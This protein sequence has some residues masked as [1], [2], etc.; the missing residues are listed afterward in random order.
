M[1]DVIL[2]PEYEELKNVVERLRNEL[3]DKLFEKDE[4]QFVICKN[5]DMA[6]MLK[7]G[8]LEY[9]VYE[10]QCE[11]LRLKRKQELIQAKKNRQELISIPEIE[12]VLD[13]EFEEYQ[14]KLNDQIE[15]MNEALH[16]SK[17]KALTDEDSKRFK[18]MYHTVVKKL[19]PDLNPN[20]TA[21]QRDMFEKAVEAYEHGDL[22][23][24]EI[25]HEMINDPQH[26][27]EDNNVM[28]RLAYEKDRLKGL[29]KVIDRDI[30]RIKREYPY[31]VKHLVDDERLME[32]ERNS[33]EEL[34]E[35]YKQL[36]VEFRSAIEE[37]LRK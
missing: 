15:K 24:M 28:K 19:H 12:E 16:R 9:K 33:L 20:V 26:E 3:S 2:F 5:I 11:W 14:T 1:N 13:K 10:A 30:E 31:S 7:L 27:P 37:M 21:A 32:E 6:Y 22:Q 17:G 34:F 4:L 35:Q 25:I 8:A 23:T 36:I 18:K 29:I